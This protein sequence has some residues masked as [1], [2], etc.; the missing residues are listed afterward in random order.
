MRTTVHCL[1]VNFLPS[2]KQEG[3]VEGRPRTKQSKTTTWSEISLFV[4]QSASRW[5]PLAKASGKGIGMGHV[6]LVSDVG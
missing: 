3:A 6:E 1:A 4:L 5:L 2:F